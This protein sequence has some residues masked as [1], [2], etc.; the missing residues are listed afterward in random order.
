M[1][2]YQGL[3]WSRKKTRENNQDII[4]AIGFANIH[5]PMRQLSSLYLC[6]VS[7]FRKNKE[8]RCRKEKRLTSKPSIMQDISLFLF[9][10]CQSFSGGN[11]TNEVFKHLIEDGLKT[12][13][14]AREKVRIMEVNQATDVQ[15]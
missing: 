8:L 3:L 1:K 12:K 11:A 4:S 7:S 13:C 9:K 5:V 2:M 6:P 15:S 10:I 14:F